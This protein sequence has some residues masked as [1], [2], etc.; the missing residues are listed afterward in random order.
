MSRT[1][2]AI[3][4]GALLSVLTSAIA[5]LIDPSPISESSA[6]MIVF[7]MASIALGGMAAL[8]LVR[9]PWSRWLLGVTVV[10]MLF[11][12]SLGGGPWFW[13]SLAIGAGV[14]IGLA[15]PWLTLWVRQQPVAEKLGP[16]PVVL[17]SAG[18]CS[19]VY[20]GL[21]SYDGVAARHWILVLTAIIS[22]WAYGRGLPFGIWGFR[23]VLP[24]VTLVV[25]IGTGWDALAVALGALTLTG[26]SWTSGARAVTAVITPP[27][28]SPSTRRE[29][30]DATK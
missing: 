20:V 7:G 18:A 13:V 26:L 24:M 16:I 28:P 10:S 9:A 29:V 30:D 14:T 21:V 12:G 27:L 4:S 6:F 23:A 22:S 5:F 2:V 17:I 11:L 25:L 8:V 3:G 19:P 15:G 1:A